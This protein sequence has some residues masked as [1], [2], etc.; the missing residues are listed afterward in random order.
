MRQTKSNKYDNGSY[1][2]IKL[3]FQTIVLKQNQVLILLYHH[4]QPFIF[5]MEKIN[6]EHLFLSHTFIDKNITHIQQY[7]SISAVDIHKN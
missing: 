1:S 7:P 4:P 5:E 2:F 6:N 3:R